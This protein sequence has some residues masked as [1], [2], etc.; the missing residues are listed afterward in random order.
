MDRSNADTYVNPEQIEL[1]PAADQNPQTWNSLELL[2]S[3][4]SGQPV[5]VAGFQLPV[6]HIDNNESHEQE[7][8]PS[9]QQSS[10]RRPRAEGEPELLPY[11]QRAPVLHADGSTESFR[12]GNVR[13]RRYADGSRVL[14]EPAQVKPGSYFSMQET[15]YRPDGSRESLEVYNEQNPEIRQIS[16]YRPDGSLE[17]RESVSPGQRETERF[18]PDGSLWERTS[19]SAESF[20]TRVYSPDGRVTEIFRQGDESGTRTYDARGNRLSGQYNHADGS[21]ETVRRGENG[22]EI[23]DIRNRDGSRRIET[24]L[25]ADISSSTADPAQ[26]PAFTETQSFRPDGSLQRTELRRYNVTGDLVNQH[27]YSADGRRERVIE[28]NNNGTYTRIDFGQNGATHRSVLREL[29]ADLH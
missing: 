12:P 2:S 28:S 1:N 22:Y 5:S 6:L 3:A 19:Q 17:S 26:R 10:G 16:R 4:K 14:T 21:T 23:R 7:P 29:P 9:D 8:K 27:S 11:P 20:N 15:R 18:R 13:E 24:D 25:P